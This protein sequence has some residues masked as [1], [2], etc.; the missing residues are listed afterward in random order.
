[1][2]EEEKAH[3]FLMGLND[4]IYSNIKEQILAL[5]PLSSL[6]EMFNMVHQEEHRKSIMLGRDN[7]V[8]VMDAFV[9]TGN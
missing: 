8:E 3:Q 2:I 5:D 4:D 1:M 9:V 7:Q 6:D